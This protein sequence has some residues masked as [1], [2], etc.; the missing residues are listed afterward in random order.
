[1]SS[2]ILTG[3]ARGHPGSLLG[4]GPKRWVPTGFKQASGAADTIFLYV[5]PRGKFLPIDP[6]I[7]GVSFL[8]F[9]R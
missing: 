1:M 4:V 6:G 5:R 7:A 8:C 2:T 9:I 3:Y